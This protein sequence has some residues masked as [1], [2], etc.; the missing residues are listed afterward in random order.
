MTKKKS[1]EVFTLLRGGIKK[2]CTQSSKILITALPL[3]H[4]NQQDEK[5]GHQ[6]FL[7]CLRAA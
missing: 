6:M 7:L 5:K 2:I 3:G 1:S 4:R